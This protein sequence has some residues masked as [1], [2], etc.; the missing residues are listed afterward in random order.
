MEYNFL[1]CNLIFLSVV[2]VSRF[3]TDSLTDCSVQV[4]CPVRISILVKTT[5]SET[6]ILKEWVC[7]NA[8]KYTRYYCKSLVQDVPQSYKTAI[9]LT[10]RRLNKLMSITVV[11]RFE[12]L[13]AGMFRLRP[14]GL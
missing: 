7:E 9:Q 14:S 10:S 3:L 13:M 1:L 4:I 6:D 2:D 12:V 11:I 8:I 5:N